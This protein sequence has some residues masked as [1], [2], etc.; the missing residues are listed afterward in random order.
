MFSNNK[1]GFKM[2]HEALANIG[3]TA[4]RDNTKKNVIA[5]F[6]RNR[7]IHNCWLLNHAG[8]E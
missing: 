7:Q 4:K 1:R 8:E 6:A 3:L 5:R 2:D